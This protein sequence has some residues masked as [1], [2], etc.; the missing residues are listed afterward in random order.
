[1]VLS[2]M[3]NHVFVWEQQ[4]GRQA[5]SQEKAEEKVSAGTHRSV[6]QK[7]CPLPPPQTCGSATPYSYSPPQFEQ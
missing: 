1:M 5:G 6:S 3:M 2:F 4:G 7:G